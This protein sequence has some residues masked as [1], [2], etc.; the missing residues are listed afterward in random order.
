VTLRA[1]S[2]RTMRTIDQSFWIGAGTDY[3]GLGLA[4]LGLLTPFWGGVIH[5][6][7]TLAIMMNSSRLLTWLDSEG[8]EKEQPGQE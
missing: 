4:F 8:Q 6:G 1:L 7:H 5:I 2:R 3:F